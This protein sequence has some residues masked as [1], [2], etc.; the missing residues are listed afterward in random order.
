MAAIL[1][2][3]APQSWD[4]DRHGVLVIHG[5]TGSPQSMRPLAAA[6][7]AAGFTVELPLLPG[8]GTAVEDMIPTRWA[9]WSGAAEAAY[10]DL[11]T[12]CDQVV[13]VGL[14]MGG[15]L[16]TWL[17][18]NH[19]EVAGLVAINA[20]V[21]PQPELAELFG[22]MIEAGEETF[23]A[24]GGDIAKTGVEELS[25][26]RTPLA[27]LVSLGE[28]IDTLQPLLGDIRCPTLILVSPQDHVVPPAASD[29]L[30]ASVGGPVETVQLENSYH[31]ATLDHDADLIAERTVAFCR[32]VF[33]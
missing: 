26:D 17:A 31:V 12:R 5:F 4:G 3:A 8:H 1:E 19:G 10:Q 16:A 18:A 30:S 33:V 21:K 15:T 11:A 28:G 9:D 23:D 27:A 20:A 24:V 2:G 7:A 25:Y 32:D 22:P 13:V 29:H 6:C 14:S